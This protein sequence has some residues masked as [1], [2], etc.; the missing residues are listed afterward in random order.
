MGGK[1]FNDQ[2][3]KNR[4]DEDDEK[5]Q[6]FEVYKFI[7][8]VITTDNIFGTYIYLATSLAALCACLYFE[9]IFYS[10]E[11]DSSYAS[12]GGFVL[13]PLISYVA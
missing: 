7:N 4:T 13:Y 12:I 3:E 10:F 1:K 2:M 9:N 8:P 6:Q 5:E 11:R